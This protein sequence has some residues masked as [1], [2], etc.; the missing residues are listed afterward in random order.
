M[1]SYYWTFRVLGHRASFMPGK[2]TFWVNHRAVRSTYEE[3]QPQNGI[4]TDWSVS[5][6]LSRPTFSP[7]R[8]AHTFP[9]PPE[10]EQ[11][12]PFHSSVDFPGHDLSMTLW[13]SSK[14]SATKG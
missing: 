6:L 10:V 8:R 13:K 5:H 12:C 11:G 1:I 4:I 7:A 2:G 9:T 3:I 14:R